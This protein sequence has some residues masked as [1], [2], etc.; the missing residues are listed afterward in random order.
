[1]APPPLFSPARRK[2]VL[3]DPN[4]DSTV[5]APSDSSPPSLIV[6]PPPP[7]W[8]RPPFDQPCTLLANADFH[9]CTCGRFPCRP[10]IGREQFLLFV[11]GLNRTTTA[12]TARAGTGSQSP[13]S[14]QGVRVQSHSRE[15]ESSLTAGSQSPVS[16]QGVRVQS[17]SRESESS[18]T[19]GSQSPVSQQGVRVQSHSRE[20]E[21]S[22][23]HSS[24][25]QAT[26]LR[27]EIIPS[28][29]MSQF[30]YFRESKP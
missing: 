15:S 6:A 22:L 17:H 16:Q 7:Y 30:M 21:S 19:A 10:L 13:V 5:A 18:L 9:N 24:G 20:S 26:G 8:P 11:D 28:F 3:A 27:R 2:K 12:R 1:M 23:T 14:Q 25:R 29:S 4:T